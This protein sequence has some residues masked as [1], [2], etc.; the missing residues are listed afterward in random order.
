MIIDAHQHFWHYESQ[1]H[2]WIDD[3]MAIIRRD[4]LPQ[5]LQPVLKA[6][7]VDGTVAV[8]ADESEEETAFLLE[9]ANQHSFIRAVVGWT[10]LTAGDV[11]D[12]LAYYKSFQKLKG[13]R[14]VLQAQEPGF[15]LRPAFLHGISLLRQ[16]GFTYDILVFPK[17]L[18]AVIELVK[19]NP[20]QPF[21][22]DHLAKPYIKT[23]DIE[24]WANHMRRLSA[25]ENVCCKL[26]GMVTEAN[27]HHWKAGDFAPYL[28]VVTE[29]FGTKRLMFGS[30]WPVCLVAGSYAQVKGIVSDYFGAY[31]ENER[32]DIFGGNA[33]RFYQITE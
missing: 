3:A 7:G 17:H 31:N 27:Y 21:V 24:T 9:L 23:G 25:F 5:D 14:H 32:A 29:A 12:K 2:G 33:M 20:G 28:E 30:D 1:K 11:E 8:Q 18:N 10:D 16:F 22:I 15:M 4:F 26:S 6:N 19:A 13:F